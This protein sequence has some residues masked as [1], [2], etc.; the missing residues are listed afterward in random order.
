MQRDLNEDDLITLYTIKTLRS[1]GFQDWDVIEERLKTGFRV[2]DI[3][4]TAMF[5][6]TGSTPVQAVQRAIVTRK[7]LDTALEKINEQADMI[8]E[9]EEQLKQAQT[10]VFTV[11]RDLESKLH[12]QQ[13]KYEIEI[14]KLKTQL[15]MWESGQVKARKP[16]SSK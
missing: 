7:E 16:S 9:L 5:V 10:E 4:D 12:E 14:A 11:Q 13:L 2:K 6:D 1:E 15:E 3:P 8:D